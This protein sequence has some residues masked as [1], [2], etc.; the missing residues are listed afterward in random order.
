MKINVLFFGNLKEI[1]QVH[2][3]EVGLVQTLSA[4]QEYLNDRFPELRE[5]PYKLALNQALVHVE[6]K[7]LNDGDEVAL[8]PPYAGG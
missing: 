4:L 8:L 5:Q 2:Q 7:K 6:N 3:L 1:T